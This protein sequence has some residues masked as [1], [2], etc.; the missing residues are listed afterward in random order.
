M[1]SVATI[2]NS[3]NYIQAEIVNFVTN[4]ISTNDLRLQFQIGDKTIQVL[5]GISFEVEAGEIVSVVG[6]SGSGKTSLMMILAGLEKATSGE[7]SV[8]GQNL[9]KLSEDQLAVFRRQSVGI[10]FQNFHLVPTMTALEN[11]ALPLEFAG[12]SNAMTQASEILD[13][14]GLEDRLTSYPGQLSGGEQQ[15]V[16]I[17]RAMVAKPKIL[18]ADEP[19]G[20]LDQDTGKRVTDL[21][22]SLCRDQG[23]AMML[24]T[25]DPHLATLADRQVHLQNG[26]LS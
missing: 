24:I 16:G 23:S 25:H 11:V 22:F 3:I 8:A 15:R 17:A 7:V 9:L 19:T 13:K 18:F 2:C 14:V 21:L 5:N 20:N 4:L 26:H 1:V 6:P 12:H 10:I